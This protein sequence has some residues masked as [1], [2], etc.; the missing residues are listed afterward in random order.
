M[1]TAFTSQNQKQRIQR[2]K[3]EKKRKADGVGRWG[4]Q[5]GKLDFLLKANFYLEY[6][7]IWFW[8]SNS[9]KWK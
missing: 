3:E 4:R 8:T 5:L 6:E 2:E 7:Y 9:W 1:A